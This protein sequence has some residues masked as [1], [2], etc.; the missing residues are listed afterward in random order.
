MWFDVRWPDGSRDR[1]YSPSLVVGDHLTVGQRYPVADFLR[2]SRTALGIASDRVQAKYGF[3]C[4]RSAATLARI[5]AVAAAHHDSGEVVV[6]GF[7][8]PGPA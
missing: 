1:L 6:E 7:Q 3:P 2:R 8:P 5:E 4:S